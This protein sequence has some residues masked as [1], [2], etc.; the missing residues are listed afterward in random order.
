MASGTCLSVCSTSCDKPT[1]GSTPVLQPPKMAAINVLTDKTTLLLV[2]ALFAQETESIAMKRS[3]AIIIGVTAFAGVAVSYL[4]PTSLSMSN[5]GGNSAALSQ[6]RGMA[7]FVRAHAL[8]HPSPE[9]FLASLTLEERD[10]L[11]DLA[12]NHWIPRARFLVSIQPLPSVGAP[13]LLLAVCDTPFTNQPQRGSAPS[14]AAAY[15]DGS[16]RLL[17]PSDY[18]A[19]DRTGLVE[20]GALVASQ[21][22]STK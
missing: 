7:S 1:F 3:L 9:G 15:S 14:H 20:I 18:L 12:M 17:S 16:T 2:S 10:E 4:K 22:S 13:P 6:V 11:A 19:L 8:D 21:S 5:C